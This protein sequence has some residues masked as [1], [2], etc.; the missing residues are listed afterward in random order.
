MSE[1]GST[2]Y[3]PQTLSLTDSTPGSVIHYTLDGSTPTVSSAVYTG[4]LTIN[5]T[6]YVSAAAIAP[7]YKL[8]RVGAGMFNMVA[9]NPTA[10]LSSGSYSGTQVITLSDSTPNAAIFYTTDGSTPTTQSTSYSGSFAITGSKTIRAMAGE[11]GYANSSVVTWT[12]TIGSGS[13][14]G[15]S[16]SGGTSGQTPTPTLSPAGGTYSSAQSVTISD[17]TAGVSIY[18]TTDGSTPSTASNLYTGP[19]KVSAS[20]TLT[21]KAWSSGLTSSNPTSAAYVISSSSSSGSTSLVPF[22]SSFS[23]SQIATNGSANVT[24]GALQLVSGGSG[25]GGTGWYPTKL[26]VSEF[27]TDFN[28][29][30]PTSA[31]DGLTFTIQNDPAAT[32]A[33]GGNASGLGYQTVS[34]SVAVAFNFYESGVTGAQSVGVYTNGESPQSGAINLVGSGI[35]LHNGDSFHVHIGYSGTA[36]QVVL[37]DNVTG[38]AVTENFTIN[39]PSIVGAN[40]AYVGFTGSTG[41]HTSVQNILQW[42]Y[43]N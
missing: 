16:G 36:M 12:Y 23:S 25:Q 4:P 38:V 15:S 29:Q 43:S 31:A 13:S 2:Y 5:T 34:H 37:K 6:E 17:S 3:G 14:S 22:G 7:G 33:L 26:S 19:V 30:L 8:S 39:I 28:F 1:P 32:T 18:Y 42:V 41:G 35:N 40:T 24:G 27:S 11:K 10:N 20:E 9:A 21:A